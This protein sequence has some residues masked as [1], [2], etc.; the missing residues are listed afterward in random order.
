MLGDPEHLDKAHLQDDRRFGVEAR[1]RRRVPER[2]CR[3]TSRAL[4]DDRRDAAAGAARSDAGVA[5]A[6]QPAAGVDGEDPLR[7]HQARATRRQAA[8]CGSIRRW[9]STSRRCSGAAARPWSDA[10]AAALHP[11][12]RSSE[13]TSEG[14]AVL[15]QKLASDAWVWGD[16]IASAISQQPGR[17]WRA[18]SPIYERDYIRAWDDFL[19]D[20]QFVSSPSIRA[21]QRAAADPDVAEL[22]AA[23]H[24]SGGRASNTALVRTKPAA[25]RPHR[26]SH[27]TRRG[28]SSPRRSSSA[29]ERGGDGG[30]RRHRALAVT[31]HFQWVRQLMAGETGQTPLDAIL[32]D[33][34]RDSA[35]SSTRSAPT[36]PAAVPWRS[37]RIR[38]SATLMQTL[39]Q[40]AT[41]PAEQHARRSSREIVEAPIAERQAG[42]T[43]R[44]REPVSTAGGADVPQR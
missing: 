21:D 32:D 14:Q 23:R 38:R 16:D 20:L 8:A 9:G 7:G 35:G 34:D 15:V 40:Q 33:H 24:P 13:I 18:S 22:A 31:A 2:R 5:G 44:D 41:R 37:C 36:S 26:A 19:D 42:A 25:P 43:E 4:L 28:R 39:R 6:Q 3:H 27:S 11:R 10:D 12:R 17:W 1:R 29:A 30:A